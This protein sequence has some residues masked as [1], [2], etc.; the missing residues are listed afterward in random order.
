VVNGT[1]EF[2]GLNATGTNGA[3]FTVPGTSGT[4]TTLNINGTVI[5]RN[6]SRIP[7]PGAALGSEYIFFNNGSVFELARNGGGTPQATWAAGSTILVTGATTTA[8]SIN[9]GTSNNI[10]NLTWNCPA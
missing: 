4:G 2:T 3:T 8:P 6:F 9:V 10:G 1:W 5:F 7:L